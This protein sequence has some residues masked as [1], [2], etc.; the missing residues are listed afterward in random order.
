[1]KKS[2][3]AGLFVTAITLSACSQVKAG[4]QA[5]EVDSYG[6]PTV[7]G[8]AAEETNPGITTVD[9]IRFPARQITWDANNE[10]GAERGPYIALSNPK[11]QAEMAIPVTL[12]FD[13]TTDC[14]K[15]KRFYKDYATKDS[16]WLDENGNSTDGWVK[17]LNYTISQPAEQAVIAITQKYDWRKVWNDDAVRVEYRDALQSR[18]QK[19]SAAR[20]GGEEFF[21][22]FQVTVGKPYPTDQRLRDAVASQ[23]SSQAEAAAKQTQATADANARRASAEADTQAS[24]A[25]KAA[26]EAE[27][28]K[29]LAEIAGFGTGPE[30]VDAWL[31]L[32]AIEKGITPWPSPIIAGAR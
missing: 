30:A 6:A 12:T 22:N 32:Q 16:G 20:T 28:Q 27:A 13:L 3:T 25:E 1:M 2:I 29:Q 21:T 26:K 31:R 8:C 14:E 17:L 4:T 5:V 7:S 9:L 24:M 15:L 10:P 11:D 18:L 23:Q 19:E